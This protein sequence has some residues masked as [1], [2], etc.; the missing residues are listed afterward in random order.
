MSMVRQI[1]LPL[2]HDAAMGADDFLV[3][4]SNRDA[5]AW[6]SRWPDWP[7]HGL[8]L[9]GPSGSGKTHLLHLWLAH[10]GGQMVRKADLLARDPVTIALK[11]PAIALDDVDAYAGDA[12]AEEA[13]FH[14][15]NYQKATKGSLL[16]A[17]RH[18]AGQSGFGLPDL[19]SRLLTLPAAALADPDDELLSALY[20]KQFRDRQIT[21]DAATASYLATHGARDAA[22]IRDLIERLDRAALAGNRKITI[23]L[24]RMVMENRDE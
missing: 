19:R 23:A 12:A 10:S 21:L 24:A 17:L 2:P 5:A 22:G 14:L 11:N 18:G 8:I 16:L 20:V 9:T 13:L 6:V 15:Y 7:A 1:P 4:D 3:T